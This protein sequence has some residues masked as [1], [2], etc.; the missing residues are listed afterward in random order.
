MIKSFTRFILIALLFVVA[1]SLSAQVI[2]RSTQDT[3]TY[4]SLKL[5][6]DAIN[7]GVFTGSIEVLI[8]DNLVETDPPVLKASGV[9]SANYTSVVIFPTSEYSISGNLGNYKAV[10]ILE[11]ADN[12]T[13]DG[14]V[15]R[16]GNSNGLTI[17]N[18]AASNAA[19]IW[20]ARASSGN[21]AN[22]V[23]IR[24][25]NVIGTSA[26]TSSIFGIVGGAYS[27]T[28]FT[29]GG[30]NNG[31]KI[32]NCNVYRAY[33]AIRLYATSSPRA[34]GVEIRNNNIGN[35]GAP[36]DGCYYGYYTYY[37]DGLIMDNN[38]LSINSSSACYSY[39][40]YYSDN[41]TI[42]NNTVE[43]TSTGSSLYGFYMPYAT[44]NYFEN[45]S[46]KNSNCTALYGV[47]LTSTSTGNTFNNCEISNISGSSTMYCIYVLSSSANNTFNN[48]TVKNITNSSTSALAAVYNSSG[49]NND[50]N[51]LKI[52]NLQGNG[53]NYGIYLAS[54]ANST[55]RNCEITNISTGST[56]TTTSAY[57][58]YV[59]S[60]CDQS[61]FYNNS[62]S[63]IFDA[64]NKTSLQYIPSGIMLFGSIG[65]QVYNNSINLYGTKTV[66][67][68]TQ[69]FSA[70][71]ALNTSVTGC[72]I[73]NNSIVN[74]QE[75]SVASAKS[76]AIYFG[77]DAA[78]NSA[79][80]NY[81]NYLVSGVNAV[82]AGIGTNDF[83]NLAA[84][85][86][87]DTL[88]NTNSISVNPLYN[89]NSNLRPYYNSPL[90]GAGT[91]I[92][93]V[94]TDL[95]GATRSA[96]APTLGAFENEGDFIAPEIVFQPIQNT[97]STTNITLLVGISD[98]TAVDTV[99]KPRLYFR[100]KT[101]LNT[102]IDN[103]NQTNGWKY[104]EPISISGN[105]Y[106]FE[107]DYSKIYGGVYQGTAIEY[108]VIAQDINNPKN[109]AISDGRFTVAPTSVNLTIA[110]FPVSVT[111]NYVIAAP[112]SGVIQVGEGHTYTSLTK[113]GGVFELLQLS[114][115][116]GDLDIQITS[117]LEETGQIP[118]EAVT[119]Q[120]GSYFIRIYPT[121]NYTISGTGLAIIPIEDADR[122][123]IDGRI[124]A[125][126]NTP[127]LTIVNNGP[128]AAIWFYRGD[129]FNSNG[130][131]NNTVRYCNI[132]GGNPS[133]AGHFGIA[134][135]GKAS[136]T[137]AA[138]GNNDITV[139]YNNIYR[140]YFGIRAYGASDGYLTGLKIRNNNF[141]K[142]LT[143]GLGHYY[144]IYTYFCEAPEITD[145]VIKSATSSVHYGMYV[146]Y[147]NNALI[148]GNS[149]Q[150]TSTSTFY[151]YYVGY[152]NNSIVNDNE[153]INTT[154]TTIYGNYLYYCN[155]TTS[156][157]NLIQNN[158][159]SSAQY[160]VYCYYGSANTISNNKILDNQGGSSVGYGI[161]VYYHSNG[162][163]RSNQIRNLSSGSTT[164]GIYL[165][166]S[167][168]NI[169]NA[170]VEKNIVQGVS[171]SGASSYTAGI[172]SYYGHQSK[173]YNNSISGI[174]K[175]V[176]TTDA[177]Y[178]PAGIQI[179]YGT[180][181]DI[182]HNTVHIS[183]DF[184]SNVSG[185]LN[186]SAFLVNYSSVNNLNIRNNTFTN[187]ATGT[188]NSMHYAVLISDAASL[189][190]STLN[191]NNYYTT[192]A[193]SLIGRIGTNNIYSLANWQ[194]ATGQDANSVSMLPAYNSDMFPI[195]FTN[196]L[197]GLGTPIAAVTT[198]LYDNA[199]STTAP[200]IGAFEV[201][202]DY[203]APS[204]QLSLLGHTTTTA[205]RTTTA[206]IQDLSGIA[207]G[208][209]APRIYFKKK[210]NANTY[211]DNTP[212]TNGWKY[213]VA[214]GTA[215]NYSFTINTALLF[216]GASVGDEIEYFV[217]AQDNSAAHKVAISHGE[218]NTE[219]S[220]VQLVAAN[221]PIKRLNISYKIKPQIAG[222]IEV[223]AGKQFENLTGSNGAFAYIND[224]VLS[225][226]L[227]IKLTSDLTEP[228][229]IRLQEIPSDA[230][231]P[232]TIY[233]YPTTE[234]EISGPAQYALITFEDVD[235]VVFDGRINM[236]GS[237][238]AI[239]LEN[240]ES[241]QSVIWV[242]KGTT[243]TSNGANNVTLRNLN[244]IGPSGT[245]T[246]YGIVVGGGTSLTSAGAC[247]NVQILYNDIYRCYYG[248]RVYASSS[249]KSVGTKIKF[250]SFGNNSTP[251][252]GHYYA[253]YI[254]YSD[255]TEITNNSIKVS[256]T[257]TLYNIYSYYS[258]NTFVYSN[259]LSN[260]VVSS[261]YYG[262]Y[263]SYSHYSSA[264]NN[265]IENNNF[266]STVYA[267]YPYYSDYVS[268]NNNI[269][270][271][272]TSSSSSYFIYPYYGNYN[273]VVGNVIENN[274]SSYHYGI[275]NYYATNTNIENNIT[276]N[277]VS[278]NSFY[279]LYL[280][281]PGAGNFNNNE[282]IDNTANST[283]YGIYLSSGGNSNIIGNTIKNLQGGSSMYGIYLT[284]SANVK[285]VANKI[286]YIR[287]TAGTSTSYC[288]GIYIGSSCNNAEIVNNEIAGIYDYTNKTSN[289]YMP[290]G[291]RI[292]SSVGHKVYYNSVNMYGNTYSTSTAAGASTAL[293][294]YTSSTNNI[295]VRNNV[296]VNTMTGLSNYVSYAVYITSA[297]S[298]T[299][300]TFN[301]NDYYV[302][303]P[304]AKL[305]FIE[306]DIDT[307]P[308]LQASTGQDVNSINVNP[309]FNNNEVLV[310]VD[311]S[312]LEGAATPIAGYTT[313]LLGNPRSAT[314][315]NIGAYEISGDLVPPSITFIPLLNT[316]EVSNR[317]LS[318]TVFDYNGVNNTSNPPRIYFRKT[319]NANTFVDNTP[320]TDGW[321]YTTGAGSGYSF[322]FTIDY[323]LIYGGVTP[324]DEIEYFIVAQDNS[325]NHLT[326]ASSGTFPVPL[327]STLLNINNFPVENV[328]HS[329]F[330]SISFAG[331]IE[332]GQGKP[333]TSL[334]NS[335]GLFAA[336]NNGILVGNLQIRITS[337]LTESG[338]VP[339]KKIICENNNP[340]TIS[341]YPTGNY[342]ISGAAPTSMITFDGAERVTID[343]RINRTGSTNA[344]T[345]QNSQSS[346][347][348]IRMM[349]SVKDITIRN[350]NII[351]ASATSTC[352]G[353][354]ASAPSSLTTGSGG[355]DNISIL[356]NN[357]YRAYYGIRISGVSGEEILSPKVIG[358]KFGNNGTS[359]DGHYYAL[360]V[361]YSN[362]AV[363]DSNSIF[364]NS[365]S[366]C[367]AIYNYRNY[368]SSV[369][370]NTIRYQGTSSLYAIYNYYSDFS[371]VSY[372]RIE[373]CNSSLIYGLY[374]YYPKNAT[375]T[376]NVIRNNSSTST[377][378]YIYSYYTQSSTFSNNIVENN[379]STSTQ[380]LG[381][382]YY[383]SGSTF[384]NNIFRNNNNTGTSTVYGIYIY[385]HPD[386]VIS[387][388]TISGITANSTL[389]GIYIYSGSTSTTSN[390]AQIRNNLIEN[391]YR[392][393]NSTTSY[394]AG[395]AI[396]ANANNA[397]ITNN[398][399][400]NIQD[401]TPQTTATYI[402]SG[403][404]INGSTGHT[405][406][407]NTVDLS[408][409]YTANGATMSSAFVIAV[410]DLTGCTIK[411][412]VFSNSMYGV[413][414]SKSYAVF[415]DGTGFTGGTLDNNNY[416][417]SGPQG[418]VAY[419][420]GDL[421]NLAT[422]RT[423]TNVDGNSISADPQFANT[424]YGD[425]RPLVGSPLVGAGSPV[426]GVTTDR[427]GVTRS[428]TT[429]TIGAFEQA[430][431]IGVPTLLSPANAQENISIQPTLEWG[432]VFTAT[433]YNLQV[434]TSPT[435]T[436]FVYN[437]TVTTMQKQLTGLSYNTIYYWRAR[438]VRP[439]VIGGWSEVYSFRT[440]LPPLGVPN[441]SQPFDNATSVA[442]NPTFSWSSVSTATGYQLQVASDATFTTIVKDE[443][444]TG[445]SK[446]VTGLSYNT[447][448]WWRVRALRGT[449][450]GAWSS[451]RS[452]TTIVQLF[453]PSLQTPANLA[454]NI[455]IN[456]TL[457]WDAYPTATGY[458]I[459][460][461][462]SS[463]FA[464][465]IVNET[466][467]GT[468]RA[469]S[470]LQYLTTYYWRVKS[471]RGSEESDWSAV[472]SF[473]TVNQ[474][475][476]APVLSSP[477]NNSTNVAISPTLQ[478]NAAATATGYIVQVSTSSTFA[479]TIVNET[480][481]GTSRALSNL[482]YLTT[483]YWRV[484]SVRGSEES[485]WSAVWSFTTVNQPLVAPV[486]SSPA[487]NA[488][489]VAI[490][491]TLQWN[492]A[493]TATGYIVQV[494]TSST[495]ATT[496]VNETVTGT[497]RA[498]SNLQYLTTYYWRVKS[499]RGS[500]ESDWS[501]VW[502][503]TTESGVIT[504]TF[505]LVN[506]WNMISAN[507][508]PLNGSIPTL[509]APLSG[510]LQILRNYV[511]QSYVPP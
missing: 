154:S 169:T 48:F 431:L 418:I 319:S 205:N 123:I 354:V 183:G 501:A 487:N 29:G 182:Y 388:N 505:P 384:T 259:T 451:V 404:R 375:Y 297:S 67:G 160:I 45:N 178:I 492:A 52:S 253:I 108:F 152:N 240:T 7:S 417:V 179:I 352:Y 59:S 31:V 61:K 166:N 350:C 180:N 494:S 164:I 356:Y 55:V 20:I 192:G 251:D 177:L 284:S 159:S 296:F 261:T 147:C 374:S 80:I 2:V 386:A 327:T 226:D 416:F 275:Y 35:N 43:N 368:Y 344:L 401:I 122:V 454:T 476:V 482:Q 390:N 33:Y 105:S 37:T 50:Y 329:Y 46:V 128:G 83:A 294:V 189:T 81:N 497:S 30:T 74:T 68:T 467:T 53:N 94:T 19:G 8:D 236:T 26:S 119:S 17:Q 458:K 288:D 39:Y 464:T 87:R 444:V 496:I 371:D 211:V 440:Q 423:L 342:T 323:N 109:V 78:F 455:T 280:S 143:E 363:I 325:P 252:D 241:S 9:G 452:F 470:N 277:N 419:F 334:T 243:P 447:Q 453:A 221:F 353:I 389:A 345:I 1:H 229:T 100:K 133:T 383:G 129:K 207:T 210:T 101:N 216:G 359:G 38:K 305:A 144:A 238:N 75:N 186:S 36:G 465:T 72:N 18:T 234:I 161:Y 217:V 242:K 289:V 271:N 336:L 196:S 249:D 378:Y 343:G 141:G 137:V 66:S 330:I 298:L 313:D 97:T 155:N 281:S 102:F 484:K 5:A 445:T 385:Y 504:Q 195:P 82:L 255:S 279:G 274:S 303:G 410:T 382:L 340:Y 328:K 308:V 245:S 456:P 366:A 306:Q 185:D 126:G 507:V 96:T 364:N 503:F 257:G 473:T 193:N 14:R 32:L 89:S 500:E 286:N 91:P 265:I 62:I 86:N 379:L 254:Y 450:Q 426:A 315:P 162:I 300:S 191:Y 214:T 317:T 41:G 377:T 34:T 235:N 339:L 199:R 149:I 223:G 403:I 57:G 132:V 209:N 438:A 421:P 290:S 412:N 349:N 268:V 314:I 244:I 373:N 163:V 347:T 237:S 131:R 194:T 511:G 370:Y 477:A 63:G 184:A 197:M 396:A 4:A 56:S 449:E 115:L 222:I 509:M 409:E 498:L 367:Y 174:S 203:V 65:H 358:N 436:S 489:D 321:K 480:V 266:S 276:K 413:T 42:T 322:N 443:T 150:S 239:T 320:S 341:I 112:L 506:G 302:S 248:V 70:G 408:G 369:K 273:S 469:L 299:N 424:A 411:N 262:I 351:S 407:Y 348:V 278:T 6:F 510:N 270:R 125:T 224:R 333:F 479:T 198:D 188:Q 472:W 181:I 376:G 190:G 99:N 420:S 332:V 486:L 269:I 140:A 309:L 58:I 357:I 71:I 425:Y 171:S 204:I 146:Y 16:T 110:N 392:L 90:V 10:I 136:L 466:V 430:I 76:F 44:N 158:I 153:L 335:D 394:V 387:G 139:E 106:T 25:V 148:Q 287:Q 488:I 291:I 414:G 395:I 463:T 200:A 301:Y 93:I 448:Y 103:T 459:Q 434:S 433:G 311:G 120:G 427:L 267:I 134:I 478:W 208:A 264:I 360:Y 27:T 3:A 402:P 398:I 231:T 121:G 157:N 437:D 256:T 310:P 77:A 64:V 318:A 246:S 283:T 84:F 227:H 92:G 399:I 439:G 213:T 85:K 156:S 40:I 218:F 230:T 381:Y 495:F 202:G 457:T 380:Y 471:V 232:Y 130:A 499:V 176:A 331:I 435:F 282:I 474:P 73:R 215:P 355:N 60:S 481:T 219:P 442:I 172:A 114:V 11:D 372:N 13:I 247:R 316:S 111:S 272:N 187:V 206:T 312:P 228:G 165:Y 173:I 142:D 113:P 502:S 175:T 405:I 326:G 432:S 117:D 292:H 151:G 15:N 393:S 461:S 104:V 295:D 127:A 51:G 365:T 324:G 460:V 428:A 116:T 429:P 293:M 21:G 485:D 304:N 446:S 54:A 22:N 475:L 28:S 415:H 167:S 493:A 468:S 422:W 168:S 400:R 483:Y 170:L 135:S 49:S 397:R 346:A 250:N 124:N 145:N 258:N 391:I 307:F 263:L 220:S 508:E 285:I 138:A 225:G 338:I 201:F 107:I 260:S 88:K 47:Y 12:V 462:T 490:S 69:G 24:N 406:A 98:N 233:I 491:P 212:A 79:T 362:N 95:D 441:L 23:T 118:L 337:N 361:S